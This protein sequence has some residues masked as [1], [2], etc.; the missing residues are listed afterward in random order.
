[1][2]AHFRILYSIECGNVHTHKALS[3]MHIHSERGLNVHVMVE[4]A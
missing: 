2:Y 3:T 4:R 1:V